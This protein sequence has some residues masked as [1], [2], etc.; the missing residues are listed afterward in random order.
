MFSKDKD[1]DFRELATPI[2]KKYPSGFCTKLFNVQPQILSERKV[3]DKTSILGLLSLV[4]LWA[5]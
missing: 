2:L 4:F 1:C 5:D 3:Y